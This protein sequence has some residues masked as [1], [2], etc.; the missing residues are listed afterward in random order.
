MPVELCWSCRK[1]KNDVRLCDDDRLCHDCDVENERKLK[2]IW[3]KQAADGTDA[4]AATIAIVNNADKAR[5]RLP[6]VSVSLVAAAN[7]A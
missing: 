4:T 6:S 2:E 1:L 5:S 7:V 3:A